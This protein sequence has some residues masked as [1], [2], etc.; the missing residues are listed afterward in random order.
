MT[1]PRLPAEGPEA[2]RE[3]Q[4]LAQ[5]HGPV[6]GDRW[7]RTRRLAV[8]S[9][10]PTPSPFDRQDEVTNANTAISLGICAH[11]SL[12]HSTAAAEERRELQTPDFRRGAAASPCRPRPRAPR[13]PRGWTWEK[14]PFLKK[15][16][17]KILI[18]KLLFER[19]AKTL[20]SAGVVLLSA[21]RRSPQ[22][23]GLHG[24]NGNAEL[25]EETTRLD[26]PPSFSDGDS[27]VTIHYKSVHL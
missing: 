19:D 10:R 11:G 3:G 13:E 16:K 9:A 5:S 12:K 6:S 26:P 2:P 24:G 25:P 7:G 4:G 22:V 23:S 27:D 21:A 18:V 8:E 14:L 1:T 20:C 15:K 17:K